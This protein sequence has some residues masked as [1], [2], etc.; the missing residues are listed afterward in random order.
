MEAKTV[1][2]TPDIARQWL[3]KNIVNRRLDN[4]RVRQ[5]A[6]DMKNGAWELNGESIKFDKD[7]KLVDGQHRLNGIIKAN[8]PIVSLVVFDLSN[9]ALLDRGRSRSEADSLVIGGKSPEVANSKCVGVAKLHYMIQT[10]NHGVPPYSFIKSFIDKY[11]NDLLDVTDL[12]RHKG[13]HNAPGRVETKNAIFMAA[14]FYAWMAG[15]KVDT[16]S[17]FINVLSTGFYDNSEHESA[18]II[19]R[20]DYLS[21]TISF[22]GGYERVNAVYALEKAIYDFANKIDRKKS[23]K[24]CNSQIYS[25]NAIF[26]DDVKDF[27]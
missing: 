23:Y 14:V 12:F 3:E 5:Y 13:G 19:I 8:V 24:N 7:G 4:F 25:N 16:L 15:E 21:K 1:E 20:N 22:R 27:V 9:V 18:A 10:G 17:R 2:I 11:E 6:I 26:K